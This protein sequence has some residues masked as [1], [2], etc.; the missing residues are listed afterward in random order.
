MTRLRETLE[1]FW[2]AFENRHS[3]RGYQHDWSTFTTWLAQENEEILN[4]KPSAI[5]RYINHLHKKGKAK[6]TRARALSVIRS[7]Y[8][9][10]VVNDLLPANPA[11]SVKNVKVDGV[12][13]TPWLNEDDIRKLFSTASEASTW[14]E[15]RDRL[16]LLLFIGLGW[17]RAEVARIRVE[18]FQDDVVIF[19]AKRDKQ[20]AVKV[21]VWLKTEV[22]A[23]L[24][25]A[26][27]EHGI[28]LR[29]SPENG[30]SISGTTIYDIVKAAAERAGFSP[31][32][33]TPHGLRR[34]FATIARRRGVSLKDVQLAMGHASSRTTEKY[35]KSLAMVTAPGEV[36]KDLVYGPR[37]SHLISHPANTLPD[38]VRD[39]AGA[40]DVREPGQQ[41]DADRA[42]PDV[43]SAR[44]TS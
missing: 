24:D 20:V 18:D 5:Q 40:E 37:I 36:L 4:I 31:A 2:Q 39:I 15:R 17:R 25:Y 27:I 10:L 8:D 43:P 33:V 23:W 11:R 42:G 19:T 32:S 22:V 41:E 6:T 28:I 1:E 3:K 21:P 26:E 38:R 12:L 35:D 44:P 29:R 16:C 13:K 30:L 9:A 34:T 14:Y 7:I